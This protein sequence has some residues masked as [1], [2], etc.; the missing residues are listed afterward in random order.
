MTMTAIIGNIRVDSSFGSNEIMNKLRL[1]EK[2]AA[3]HNVPKSK[4]EEIV[5]DLFDMIISLVKGG[6]EVT[7]V[8]F[9]TFSARQRKGRI[10]VNPQKP[11]EQ[12][13]IPSVVVPKF[14]SGKK[15]KDTLKK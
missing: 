7:L 3:K 11:S 1:S 5:D 15:F 8:G 9:G 6:E 2:L 4:M 13:Q 10:G 12:I 14:K